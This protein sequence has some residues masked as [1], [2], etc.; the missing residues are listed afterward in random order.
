MIPQWGGIAIFNRNE[1]TERVLRL[2]EM[3]KS[4]QL[5]VGQ[6]REL[7]GIPPVNF[8]QV[9]PAKES[10]LAE[11]ERDAL[12]RRYATA[13]VRKAIDSLQSMS[14]FTQNL[15]NMVLLDHIGS[16]AHSAVVSLQEVEIILC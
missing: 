7:L 9:V 11:W 3:E 13:N 10:G 8:D 2:K 4:V 12:A 16:L 6:L 15:N 14:S 1:T 5:F